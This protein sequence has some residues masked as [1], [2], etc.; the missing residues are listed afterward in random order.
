MFWEKFN[1]ARVKGNS[2]FP[3]G[4]PDFPLYDFKMTYLRCVYFLGKI[5]TTIADAQSRAASIALL[6]FGF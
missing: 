2:I 6:Y 5:D 4:I 1:S 3:Y